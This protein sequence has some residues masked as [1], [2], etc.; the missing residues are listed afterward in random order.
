MKPNAMLA[1]SFSFFVTLFA[2]TRAEYIYDS[3]GD[4]LKNGGKY[5]I[6]PPTVGGIAIKAAA[7]S[8]GQSGACSL[9]VAAVVSYDKGWAAK[10]ATPHPLNYIT[11]DYPLNMSF[12]SLPSNRCT[13]S[14]SWIVASI[15]GFDGDLVMVGSP[16]EFSAPRSG[17]FYIKKYESTEFYKF[18][19][20]YSA[21][22]CGYVTLKA[23]GRHKIRLVISRD[24]SVQPMAVKFVKASTSEDVDDS[25]ISM[26]V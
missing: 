8:K 6:L 14:S 19:F 21:S 20:C 24:R 16:E 2:F 11:N 1:L 7:I 4:I 10:I 13:N 26:V 17:Y 12:A 3:D 15:V 25:G 22:S 23:D 18:A 9:T 5:Y